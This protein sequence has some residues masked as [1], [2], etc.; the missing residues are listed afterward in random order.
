MLSM[1]FWACGSRVEL[2]L[3]KTVFPIIAN[4]AF[5]GLGLEDGA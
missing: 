3:T 4:N 2:K 1:L 5:L